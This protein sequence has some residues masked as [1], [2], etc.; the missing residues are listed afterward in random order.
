MKPVKLTTILWLKVKPILNLKNYPQGFKVI[1]KSFLAPCL[2]LASLLIHPAFAEPL[3][4]HSVQAEALAAHNH[5]RQ[6][7]HAPKL[8]WDATLEQF[9]QRHASR[10]VFKHSAQGYGENLAAGYPTITAAVNAWYAESSL[11]SYRYPEYSPKT[12]H[13]TQLVWVSTEK[14]GCA[15][16]SCNGRKGTPGRYL[17]CEYFPA[18]NVVNKGYFK[19]NVLPL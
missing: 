19:E 7:H 9:A 16:V 12:G 2:V 11:Y 3:H 17:V 10:C 5:W 15:Y 14:V 4:L 1:L 13:F 18:G 8:H 6:L